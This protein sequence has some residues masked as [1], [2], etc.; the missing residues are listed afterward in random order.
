LSGRGCAGPMM[1]PGGSVGRGVGYGKHTPT[2]PGAGVVPGI[3]GRGVGTMMH[4]SAQPGSGV[5]DTLAVGRGVGM[6]PQSPAHGVAEGGGTVCPLAGVV[7][8]A[9]R[10]TASTTT[11]RATNKAVRIVIPFVMNSTIVIIVAL[12]WAEQSV[13]FVRLEVTL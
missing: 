9:T 13:S 5:G 8:G 6:G 4:G 12:F 1:T 2:H 7:G 3:M 10:P 11:N